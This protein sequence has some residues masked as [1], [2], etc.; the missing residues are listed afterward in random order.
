V[1]E[2]CEALQKQ[3]LTEIAGMRIQAQQEIERMHQ[4]ALAE[5]ED[6]QHQADEYADRVLKNME[7]QLTEILRVIRN[8]RQQLQKDRPSWRVSN[9]DVSTLADTSSTEEPAK[10]KKQGKQGKRGREG[11]RERG[12]EGDKGD[13]G[14]KGAEDI[15]TSGEA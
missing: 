1:Q 2:E 4:M 13:K 14:D 8:G 9:P 5:R 10:V 6:I 7:Q 12:K 3:T 15:R 11:E